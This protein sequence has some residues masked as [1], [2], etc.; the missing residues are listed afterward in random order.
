MYAETWKPK[1]DKTLA[2]GR[3]FCV[4]VINFAIISKKG[5]NLLHRV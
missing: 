2:G 5:N 4:S 1:I 3:E